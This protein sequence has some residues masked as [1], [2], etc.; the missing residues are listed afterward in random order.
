MSAEVISEATSSTS[1]RTGTG[2][3]KWMPITCSGRRVA[4]AS[5]MIGIE[6]VLEASTASTSVTTSSSRRKASTLRLWSSLIASMTMSRSANADQSSV[7]SRR[8]RAAS[9]S[10]SLSLPRFERAAERLLHPR[11]AGL[12]QRRRGLHHHHVAAVAGAHLGDA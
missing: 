12:D 1:G 11:P 9:W 8:A 4:V 10:A 5:F 7:K 6:D 2:L 3:K